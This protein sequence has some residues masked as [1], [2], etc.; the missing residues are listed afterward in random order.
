[1]AATLF[2]KSLT[3]VRDSDTSHQFEQHFGPYGSVAA[4]DK[5]MKRLLS[6]DFIAPAK[7]HKKMMQPTVFLLE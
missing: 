3:V 5:H 2:I 4:R 7:H 1:M 6:N